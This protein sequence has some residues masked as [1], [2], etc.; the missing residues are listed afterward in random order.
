MLLS[1]LWCPSRRFYP[2]CGG[3][4]DD[5]SQSGRRGGTVRIISSK[6]GFFFLKKKDFILVGAHSFVQRAHNLIHSY[7]DCSTAGPCNI[8]QFLILGIPSIFPKD[9][10]ENNTRYKGGVKNDRCQNF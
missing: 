8:L 7:T 9:N 6:Y 3:C 4:P 1:P 5:V 2:R 10:G